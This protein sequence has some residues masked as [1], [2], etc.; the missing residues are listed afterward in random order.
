L[1]SAVV[2]TNRGDA[3]GGDATG[4]PGVGSAPCYYCNNYY[5]G[6]TANGEKGTG[7]A[8][9]GYGGNIATPPA[10]PIPFSKPT[11][12]S[13]YS[14][15]LGEKGSPNDPPIPSSIATSPDEKNKNVGVNTSSDN[16]MPG[17]QWAKAWQKFNSIKPWQHL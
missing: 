5:N 7:A 10:S 17:L 3:R 14:H 6:G 9:T 15:G 16:V 4:G 13:S 12:S 2:C 1:D 11:T 8:A